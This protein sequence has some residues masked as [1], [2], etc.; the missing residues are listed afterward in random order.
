MAIA[1]LIGIICFSAGIYVQVAKGLS[2]TAGIVPL[3]GMAFM[4]GW[5]AFAIGRLACA[6]ETN[7]RVPGHETRELIMISASPALFICML[8]SKTPL[9]ALPYGC[10]FSILRPWAEL[11]VPR[12]ARA[13]TWSFFRTGQ[14]RVFAAAAALRFVL[15]TRSISVAVRRSRARRSSNRPSRARRTHPKHWRGQ[16]A[17]VLIATVEDKIS[18]FDLLSMKVAPS[19]KFTD[20]NLS[21]KVNYAKIFN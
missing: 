20:S 21:L 13:S 18:H 14:R 17:I 2:S 4:A 7:K 6:V 19:A 3:G 11:R 10:G 5:A 15:R 12:R 8:M 1:F 16:C 9:A